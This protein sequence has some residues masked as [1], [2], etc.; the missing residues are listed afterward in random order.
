MRTLPFVF[1]ALALAASAGRQPQPKSA[2]LVKNGEKTEVVVAVGETKRTIG[3]TTANWLDWS[4]RGARLALHAGPKGALSVWRDGRDEIV[5]VAKV[6]INPKWSPDGSK[7]LFRTDTQELKV[8]VATVIGS[9]PISIAKDVRC[10]DWSPDGGR[11]AYATKESIWICDAT[12]ENPRENLPDRTAQSLS[13]SPNGRTLAFIEPGLGKGAKPT[14]FAAGVNGAHVSK[15]TALDANDLS[16]SPNG[17]YV[18]ASTASGIEILEV[19]R[20]KPIATAA[21]LRGPLLWSGAKRIVGVKDGLPT[22]F[23]IGD[24]TFTTLRK[25]DDAKP[26]FGVAVPN[27]YLSEDMILTDPLRQAPKPAANQMALRGTVVAMEPIEDQFTIAIESVIDATGEKHFNRPVEQI[28]Q[29]EPKTLRFVGS[30]SRPLRS[31]D[32]K[33]DDDVWVVVNATKLDSKAILSMLSATIAGDAFVDPT[34]KPTRPAPR[35]K[36]ETIEYDGVSMEKVV[37]PMTFPVLGKVWYD[38]WFLAPRGGGTRRHHGQDLMAAKMTP[39]VACFDGIV[40]VGK[41]RPGGHMT[42]RIKGSN[43]WTACY[44]HVNNDTP[45]TDDGRGGETNAFAPGLRTGQYVYEGQFIGYVGDSGNAE[46]TGPHCHFELWDERFGAVVNAYPSLRAGTRLTEPRYVAPAPELLPASGE[47][48]VD[49]ILR[50]LDDTKQTLKMEVIARYAG[51]RMKVV[52]FPTAVW[53][54]IEPRSLLE[55]RGR[56]NMPLTANDLRAGLKGTLV[57]VQPAKDR[58]ILTRI[59]AFERAD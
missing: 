53:G 39:M 12:G 1:V 10:A 37:V 54:K 36:G 26:I 7:L 6:A 33:L 49:G 35:I 3:E 20:G 25:L 58:A 51:G 57:G 48:R 23:V 13:W 14:L 46:T 27:L 43:G 47:A 59:G 16:W 29:I 41:A 52:T 22:E 21:G 28:V 50:K 24:N 44:Y 9:D 56:R 8:Y 11:I 55:V 40:I 2:F 17:Q 32:L 34:V 42:L 4:P 30:Q 19:E 15:K 18:A 31:I 38:D 45:G 5:E